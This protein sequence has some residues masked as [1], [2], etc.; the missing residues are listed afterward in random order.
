V[1]R[2]VPFLGFCLAGVCLAYASEMALRFLVPSI[3]TEWGET[4]AIALSS[5]EYVEVIRLG[6]AERFEDAEFEAGVTAVGKPV[7]MN[8]DWQRRLVA[9]LNRPAALRFSLFSKLCEPSPGVALRLHKDG[10]HIDL[11]VCFLCKDL[12]LND[13]SR[14]LRSADFKSISSE[15]A[16]LL[17]EAFPKDKVI[18]A[19][20][21]G[22]IETE[23]AADAPFKDD[24]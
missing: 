10:S 12:L 1:K 4:V 15:L 5:P 19:I 2:F 13:R 3:E 7:R 23:A 8:P 14:D 6:Q 16:G 11:L 22:D 9:A 18:Q 21:P 17:K 24:E 20:T